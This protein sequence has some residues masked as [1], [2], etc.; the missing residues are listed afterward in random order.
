MFRSYFIIHK[1]LTLLVC[2]GGQLSSRTPNVTP[3]VGLLS[4]GFLFSPGIPLLHAALSL[5][6]LDSSET[7]ISNVN[8]FHWLQEETMYFSVSSENCALLLLL[9]C[10]FLGEWGL[11][12]LLLPPSSVCLMLRDCREGFGD[13][14]VLLLGAL[15]QTHTNYY[16]L[17]VR[18]A[19]FS[20]QKIYFADLWICFKTTLSCPQ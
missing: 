14:S 20:T 15:Q 9:S 11:W 10:S 1:S 16:I 13:G 4:W 18:V 12:L 7:H 5:G 3:A 2:A 6:G 19:R 8:R 17:K